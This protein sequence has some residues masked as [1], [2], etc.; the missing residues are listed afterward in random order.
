MASKKQT[1]LTMSGWIKLHRDIL[2]HW[3]F[4][5]PEKLKAWLTILLEVN[6]K[7]DKTNFGN[8]LLKCGRGESLKSLDSWAI[9]FGSKWNKSKVRR[10]FRLLEKDGMII[11]KN[12]RKTTRIT[13][14]NYDSYQ[15][16]RNAD[17]TQ[18]KRERNADETQT[19]PNKNVKKGKNDKNIM[20]EINSP[21]LEE[22]K[23]N[24]YHEIKKAAN[25]L[26]IE[27]RDVLNA[28]YQYWTQINP[29]GRKMLFEKERTK[30]AFDTKKRLAT[31]QSKE[32]QKTNQSYGRKQTPESEYD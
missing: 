18:M 30:R 2:R 8:E 5:D 25:D 13:V 20:G 22:R 19:T 1:I 11:Q 21:T 17:E 26:D 29:R 28:F 10:F 3:I 24:F 31:W 14:C 16:E 7:P 27:S 32:K 15:H 4:D 6:H 23:N 9:L 12:E